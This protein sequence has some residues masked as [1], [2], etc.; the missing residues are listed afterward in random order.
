MK[1]S[2]WSI[3]IVLVLILVGCGSS[4]SAKYK[5]AGCRAADQM[6][7]DEAATQFNL[8]AENGDP[9]AVAPGIAAQTIWGIFMTIGN[10]NSLEEIKSNSEYAGELTLEIAAYCGSEYDIK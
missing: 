1:K 5:E 7:L 2:Y 10:A 4:Q 9:E 3:S 8:A 6:A